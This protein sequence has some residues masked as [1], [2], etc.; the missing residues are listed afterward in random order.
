MRRHWEEGKAWVF[1]DSI[2]HEAWN[3]SNE[4]RVILLFETWRPELS[5]SERT[6]VSTMLG[7]IEDGND[8]ET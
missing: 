7:S 4:T 6:L 5:E 1:D 3:R 2:E 8:W